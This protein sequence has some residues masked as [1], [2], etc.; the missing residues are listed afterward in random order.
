[1]WLKAFTVCCR[2]S[3][4]MCILCSKVMPKWLSY[5]VVLLTVFQSDPVLPYHPKIP[6]VNL[7]SLPGSF[8]AVGQ[9]IW[10]AG[11]QD[12]SMCGCPNGFLDDPTGDAATDPRNFFRYRDF[13]KD[14]GRLEDVGRTWDRAWQILADVMCKPVRV[15]CKPW[16]FLL[17]LQPLWSW[18]VCT[19][20][21]I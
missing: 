1:M 11:C 19:I 17:Y 18:C 8:R 7:D 15:L 14:V 3:D 2:W 16:I 13:C 12:C 21:Y 5:K 10:R 4:D 6:Q 9:Q 20:M